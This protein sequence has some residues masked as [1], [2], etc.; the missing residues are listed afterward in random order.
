MWGVNVTFSL[1]ISFLAI[2]VATWPNTLSFASTKCQV[3]FTSADFCMYV[4][5]LLLH[6]FLWRSSLFLCRLYF[7]NWLHGLCNF[8]RFRWLVKFLA[9]LQTTSGRFIDKRDFGH[10]CVVT[11]AITQRYH[12]HVARSSIGECRSNPIH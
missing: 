12:A 4:V 8:F 9:T 2:S 11:T 1:P 6:C 3:R 7:F 5:I 10:W